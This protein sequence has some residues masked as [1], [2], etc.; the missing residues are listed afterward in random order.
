MKIKKLALLLV[1]PLMLQSCITTMVVKEQRKANDIIQLYGWR[2]YQIVSYQ[3]METNTE[4]DLQ[5]LLESYQNIIDNQKRR[6][7][8]YVLITSSSGGARETVPPGIYA[9]YG[10]L[11]AKSGNIEKGL[12]MMRNEIKLYPE[13]SVFV[14]KII[15]IIENR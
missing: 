1:L 14:N 9:D 13:S 7:I 10:F 12:E 8:D 11:L 5:K 15:K 2:N 6:V 4:E 3:Y